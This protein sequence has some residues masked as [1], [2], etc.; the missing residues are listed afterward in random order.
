MAGVI[1]E[2]RKVLETRSE[3]FPSG[4]KAA[5]VGRGRWVKG[6]SIYCLGNRRG[7]MAS[8]ARGQG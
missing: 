5:R 7:G 4:F 8:H 2:P 3:T 1:S 6:L